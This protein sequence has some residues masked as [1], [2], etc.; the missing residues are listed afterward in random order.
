[1]ILD[2]FRTDDSPLSQIYAPL[3]VMD[4]DFF[5]MYGILL[6]TTVQAVLNP[7][8]QGVI[9]QVINERGTLNNVSNVNPAYRIDYS[10]IE[11][12]LQRREF[13]SVFTRSS[14]TPFVLEMMLPYSIVHTLE[15]LDNSQCLKR[16]AGSGNINIA[17][18]ENVLNSHVSVLISS[19]DVRRYRFPDDFTPKTY[20]I[21]IYWVTGAEYYDIVQPARNF[22]RTIGNRVASVRCLTKNAFKFV[23]LYD[24]PR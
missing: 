16:R 17:Y 4:L 23:S 3:L 18:E 12:L 20:E 7:F 9:T 21:E 24:S 13:N 11:G 2:M 6:Q 14:D 5:H 15:E 10:G 8:N 19:L 1:M 22:Y